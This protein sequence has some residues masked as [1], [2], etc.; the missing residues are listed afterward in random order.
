MTMHYRTT[1][2]AGD[3]F[4]FVI[5]DGSMD[6]HGT[7]I[8]PDGWDLSEF[9]KNPIALWAHGTDSVRGRVPI[10]RWE[11]VRI[12]AG[13]L[14]GTLVLA[15]EGSSGFVDE[16]RRLV[17]QGILRAVSVG[18]DYMQPGK[19]GG[20]WEIERAGLRE[21]AVASALPRHQ[22]IHAPSGLWRACRRRPI[23]RE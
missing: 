9:R 21:R 5:S 20:K 2:T 12:A 11:N 10:G 22:R 4:D 19:P 15:E 8:N 14:L 23:G 17:T 13:K 6:R 3:G 18:M 7:R 1:V 16:L